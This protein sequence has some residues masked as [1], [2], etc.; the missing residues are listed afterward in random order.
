[1]TLN[2]VSP[3]LRGCHWGSF[4]PLFPHFTAIVLHN[5]I[6]R[7]HS[8]E[9]LGKALKSFGSSQRGR[10]AE[11]AEQAERGCVCVCVCVCTRTHA[12]A[13]S[14]ISGSLRPHGLWPTRLLCPWDFPVKNTGVGCHFLLQGIFLTQGSNPHLLHWQR[15]S[16]PLSRLG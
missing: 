2:P 13:H 9:E 15:D 14:V 6:L 10:G 8:S 4:P 16:L 5:V 3:A 1:M 12:C 7:L 11:Q